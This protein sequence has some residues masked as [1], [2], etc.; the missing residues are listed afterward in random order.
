[1]N[2]W[3]AALSAHPWWLPALALGAFAATAALT[4]PLTHWLAA[5]QFGK[6]IRVDGPQHQSKQGT[7]TMG[8]LAMLG[9]L[10]LV[11]MVLLAGSDPLVVG[12]LL[13]GMLAFAALGLADDMAGLARRSGRKEAGIG[14]KARDMFALQLVA[15]LLLSL[16]VMRLARPQLGPEQTLSDLPLTI[17]MTVAIMGT[18][19]GVNLSDGLDG[20]AAGL[21][22]IAFTALLALGLGGAPAALAGAA[23]G[24]CLGFLLHNRYPARVFMGN[25]ASMGLGAL[26]A[27]VAILSGKLLLLPI[28]GAVFVTEVLSDLI[29]VGWFK[30]TRRRTGTGRRFFRIAPIHHHFEAIGWPET[31]VVRR[32]WLAGASAA[33]V[34]W[35]FGRWL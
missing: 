4:G 17:L 29:Q 8:G 26:L 10:L 12:M 18:V 15:A 35:L 34:A 33:F 22:T 20:L 7:P 6:A 9:V 27:V 2:P 14:L 31:R 23:V 1:M 3:I 5:R 24:A 16:S 11:G 25:V 19:N 28:V 21:L 30:W 13:L 32:F